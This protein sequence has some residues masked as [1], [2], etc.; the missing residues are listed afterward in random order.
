[1]ISLRIWGVDRASK[2]RQNHHSLIPVVVVV[3]ESGAVYSS[4][5]LAL[6]AAY[7][8]DSWT[9]YLFLESVSANTFLLIHVAL[10]DELHANNR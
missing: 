1:M 2:G 9:H 3:V 7:L 5:L 4:W 10:S 8:A 6:F